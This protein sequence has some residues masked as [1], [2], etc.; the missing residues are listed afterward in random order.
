[1]RRLRARDDGFTMV[2][3]IVVV[4]VL[5]LVVSVLGSALRVGVH[6]GVQGAA[7]LDLSHD[8]EL[9]SNYLLEDLANAT[10]VDTAAASCV[11]APVIRLEVGGE[12]AYRSNADHTMTRHD[13]ASGAEQI[14]AR[15]LADVAPTVTCVSSCGAT[16]TRVKIDIPLCSRLGDTGVCDPDTARDLRLIGRPRAG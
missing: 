7:R 9:L 4:A 3:V 15:N 12:I 13:C 14:V 1:M 8:A 11:A 16:I 10:V 6:A 5:G 2:E